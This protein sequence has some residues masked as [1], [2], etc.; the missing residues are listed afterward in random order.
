LTYL[1]QLARDLEYL[2][3]DAWS[4]LETLR[5]RAGKL[6]WGLYRAVRG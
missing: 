2:T 1:L 6:T 5:E 4:E 3:P